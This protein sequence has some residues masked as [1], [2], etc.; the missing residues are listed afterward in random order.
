MAGCDDRWLNAAER[1][2]LRWG[3]SG[4]GLKAAA[5]DDD[6]QLSA[7]ESASARAR[8]KTGR[9]DDA[10]QIL[11]LPP[12][13]SGTIRKDLRQVAAEGLVQRHVADQLRL[14]VAQ[15]GDLSAAPTLL[16]VEPFA[17]GGGSRPVANLVDPFGSLRGV[18]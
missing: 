14:T 17:K 6:D 15:D 7:P 1:R 4:F 9:A 13:N 18:Q 12:L 5:A 2:L 10:V 16:A 8:L 3:R 11:I